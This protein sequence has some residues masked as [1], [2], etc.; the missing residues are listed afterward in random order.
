M[1]CTALNVPNHFSDATI[2]RTYSIHYVT[3]HTHRCTFGIIKGI[4]RLMFLQQ[5]ISMG[6]N[7]T[8][9]AFFTMSAEKFPTFKCFVLLKMSLAALAKFIYLIFCKVTLYCPCFS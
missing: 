6:A 7:Q 4:V 9:K 2:Y 8:C 5:G 3:P 1:K